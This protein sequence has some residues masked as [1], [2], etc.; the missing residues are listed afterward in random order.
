MTTLALIVA[1]AE[2]GVIGLEGAMPWHLPAD[3]RHFKAVTLGHPMLMGRKTHES[4]GRPLPGRRN[5]VISRNAAWQAPGVETAPS[6]QAALDLVADAPLAF[7]IGGGQLYA[8]ALAAGLVQQVHLT[9]VL[10]Q[11][12]GDTFFPLAQLPEMGFRLQ[13]STP[14]P[15]D[16]QHAHALVFETWV[17]Q[18]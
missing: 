11:P 14:H 17:R 5:V 12:R 6:L 10:A 15:A 7:L 8:Q 18:Q 2:N 3:L 16:A 13:D 1:A 4:I 9:R